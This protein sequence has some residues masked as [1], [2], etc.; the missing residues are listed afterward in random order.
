MML[1]RAGREKTKTQSLVAER[2]KHATGECA[3][4]LHSL[5]PIS[6]RSIAEGRSLIFDLPSW[7]HVCLDS[8]I[9]S[10]IHSEVR[11]VLMCVDPTPED[12]HT[13]QESFEIW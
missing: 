5:K 8:F 12:R 4:Q 13:L 11:G 3:L 9:L 1:P 6:A 7:L 10:F 2:K